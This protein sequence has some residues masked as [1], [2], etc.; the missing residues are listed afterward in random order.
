MIVPEMNKAAA[1]DRIRPQRQ[2][3]LIFLLSTD[4]LCLFE[5]PF[6]SSGPPV[7][8]PV[9]I[10]EALPARFGRLKLH[11]GFP[12]P[13]TGIHNVGSKV[14]HRLRIPFPGDRGVLT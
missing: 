5:T 3:F 4:S 12:F 7:I 9:V 1:A 2:L 14:L 11:P 13:G 10:P 6:R 8:L